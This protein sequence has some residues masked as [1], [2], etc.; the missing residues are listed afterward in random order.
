[1][2]DALEIVEGCWIGT[3]LAR[4]LGLNSRFFSRFRHRTPQ[5]LNHE[6]QIHSTGG[7]VLVRIPNDISKMI[8][9]KEYV[10]SRVEDDDISQYNKVFN[11]TSDTKIGFW[12]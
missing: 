8:R 9:S 5:S 7:L 4:E 2:S 11:L 1:M 12:K 6:V 10:V 3:E